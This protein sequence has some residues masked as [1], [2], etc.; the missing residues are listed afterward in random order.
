MCLY[1]LVLYNQPAGRLNRAREGVYL[2]AQHSSQNS[3]TRVEVQVPVRV[4]F[5]A[6]LV[7]LDMA[8]R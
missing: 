5:L 3:A 6:G 4:G 8:V 2:L 1:R 7:G